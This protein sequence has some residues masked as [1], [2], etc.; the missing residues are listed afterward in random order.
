MN[1][2]KEE[3]KKH[4]YRYEEYPKYLYH[5]EFG[6]RLIQSEEEEESLGAGWQDSPAT[7]ESTEEASV[8]AEEQGGDSP[9]DTGAEQDESVT[10][11]DSE[12]ENSE[13]AEEQGGLFKGDD[14]RQSPR[15][16]RRK[17]RRSR[18]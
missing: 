12:E 4:V 9:D 5:Q 10:V 15:K 14:E 11:S 2:G 6:S 17:Q 13:E 16:K 3:E 8:E 1:F 7:F 18:N